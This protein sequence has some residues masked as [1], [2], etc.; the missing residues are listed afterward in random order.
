MRKAPPCGAVFEELATSNSTTS[1]Y[2][3]ASFPCRL[4]NGINTQ[5][6]KTQR[7]SFLKDS[8]PTLLYNQFSGGGVN[9]PQTH[10]FATEL[11]FCA[12][13]A[14]G[15]GKLIRGEYLA[16]QAKKHSYLM[17]APNLWR[18]PITA[19]LLALLLLAAAEVSSGGVE[20][21]SGYDKM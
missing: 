1:S 15:R 6:V 11:A 8:S 9:L 19:A 2:S 3:F 5:L 4:F 12:T 20:L 18:Q 16:Q 21:L 7:A 10:V 17:E 14:V 13:S